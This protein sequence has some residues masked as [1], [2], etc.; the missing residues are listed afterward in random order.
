MNRNHAFLGIHKKCNSVIVE[1]VKESICIP[2]VPVNPRSQKSAFP[3]WRN[4]N[5]AN[6]F[7]WFSANTFKSYIPQSLATIVA[8][9]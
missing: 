7:E 3:K 5:I 2:N 1:E 9:H 6:G 4:I 8:C